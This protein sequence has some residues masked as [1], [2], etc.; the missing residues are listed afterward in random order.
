M[1]F[2]YNFPSLK[3]N[4]KNFKSQKTERMSEKTETFREQKSLGKC[5][6]EAVI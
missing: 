6:V 2:F 1:I 5:Q 4:S 3:Q